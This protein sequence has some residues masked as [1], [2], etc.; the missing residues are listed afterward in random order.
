MKRIHLKQQPPEIHGMIAEHMASH[1]HKSMEDTV[2]CL[3]QEAMRR[4]DE[5]DE[6][7]DLKKLVNTHISR[8]A[9]L[10]HELEEARERILG[11]VA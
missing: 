1:D 9:T 10:K 11:L 5:A 8:N 7:E 2:T 4:F 3:I 6:I